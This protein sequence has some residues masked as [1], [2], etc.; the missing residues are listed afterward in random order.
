MVVVLCYSHSS[1]EVFG[2]E[3][4]IALGLQG[5]GHGCRGLEG[6]GTDGAGL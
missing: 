6:G 2:S 3:C 4:L 5:I 1:G